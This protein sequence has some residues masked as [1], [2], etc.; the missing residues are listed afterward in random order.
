MMNDAD[1]LVLAA[2]GGGTRCRMAL[3]TKNAIHQIEVGAANVST[4]FAGTVTQLRSGLDQLAAQSGIEP[5][6][7]FDAPSYLGLAGVTGDKLAGEL[8][9]AL[10]FARVRIQDDR[11]A[12]LRG[13]LGPGD[14]VIGHCGT[15]SFLAAQF[16]GKPRFAGGWGP[17]L[18]DQASA[19]WV[20]RWAMSRTLDAL[21][22]MVA[23]TDLTRQ[24]AEQFE[25]AA[26]LVRAAGDMSPDT[27]GAVAPLVTQAAAQ[28][29]AVAV[30]ILQDGAA[31]LEHRIT[32]LGWKPGLPICLTGGI[33]PQYATYLPAPMQAE[34]AQ[35]KGDPMAGAI[36]LAW[37]Y[38]A[39]VANE[40]R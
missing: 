18:G 12:A 32:G 27:F 21:D 30:A 37:A 17:V 28:G 16:D 26:G 6:R 29:D 25:G 34:V 11:P 22:G 13:A 24:L 7:L 39:E 35:P 33:G 38:H 3:C 2:D 15:G 19:Q 40:Y 23:Q 36:A 20:A 31:Y 10:P 8:A 1:T 4:S 9:A 14:G 5:E